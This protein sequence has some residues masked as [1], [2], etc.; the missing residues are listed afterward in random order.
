MQSCIGFNV[1]KQASDWTDNNWISY[2]YTTSS[3]RLIYRVW[4]VYFTILTVRR[5]LVYLLLIIL[6]VITQLRLL[7]DAVWCLTFILP[8]YLLGYHIH[9]KVYIYSLLSVGIRSYFDWLLFFC[10]R[11]VVFPDRKMPKRKHRSSRR[12]REEKPGCLVHWFRKGLRLHDNPALKEGL[13]SASGFRCI[14]ILDP[15]FAGSCSKGVNR[16]R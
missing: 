10:E 12:D 5:D 8:Y 11:I 9:N 6:I 7:F 2:H 16:W 3:S 1:Q 15:W 4:L 14:Y 13:K